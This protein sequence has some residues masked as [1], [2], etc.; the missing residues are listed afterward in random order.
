MQDIAIIGLGIICVIFGCINLW[1]FGRIKAVGTFRLSNE[2]MRFNL[3]VTGNY[4]ISVVG[5][6]HVEER[7]WVKVDLVLNGVDEILVRPKTLGYVTFRS[8]EIA[9]EHWIFTATSTGP[10]EMTISD[11]SKLE[12]WSSALMLRKAIERPISLSRLRIQVHPTFGNVTR[13]ASMLALVGGG[14]IVVFGIIHLQQ[15]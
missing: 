6:R 9:V 8:G 15:S 10:C 14:L 4:A 7:G 3:D 2:V 13:F 12:A 11:V 1:R 5:A